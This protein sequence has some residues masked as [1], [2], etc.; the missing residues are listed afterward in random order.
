MGTR[1]GVRERPSLKT[2]RATRITEFV[3]FW[4]RTSSGE[5]VIWLDQQIKRNMP[6]Y[7]DWLSQR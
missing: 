2:Q 6:E 7:R 5:E 4:D 1:P 3:E